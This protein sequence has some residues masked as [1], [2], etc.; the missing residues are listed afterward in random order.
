MAE[1]GADRQPPRRG[2]WRKRC[3]ITLLLLCAFPIAIWVTSP[4][5][6]P[7]A[8]QLALRWTPVSVTTINYDADGRLRLTGAHYSADG[9]DAVVEQMRVPAPAQILSAWLTTRRL[10]DVT[11]ETWQVTID[12]DAAG[13][14]TTGEPIQADDIHLPETL[15]HW[16]GLL[17]KWRWLIPS[18]SIRSGT[19]A[20]GDETFAVDE[21][22]WMDTTLALQASSSQWPSPVAATFTV[23]DDDSIAGTIE[24]AEMELTLAILI[25]AGE[26]SASINSTLQW[27]DNVGEVVV[28][29]PRQ[30]ILPSRVR[31]DIP[32]FIIPTDI[33]QLDGYN[34]PV[35]DIHISGTIGAYS[36]ALKIAAEPDADSSL[37]PLLIALNASGSEHQLEIGTISIEGDFVEGSLSS[38]IHFDLNQPDQLTATRFDF[39]ADLG[40]Q[41]IVPVSGIME[42]TIAVAEHRLA[43]G[44]I[45]EVT[46]EFTATDLIWETIAVNR[47]EAQARLR[48]PTLE[49]T[50]LAIESDAVTAQLS[51]SVH[52]TEQTIDT[53]SFTMEVRP[54]IEAVF[55]D[56]TLPY[57]FETIRSEGSIDGHW[58]D[59][60]HSG[61]IEIAGVE[62]P[63]VGKGSITAEW[64]GV[65]LAISSSISARLLNLAA[66]AR[67]EVNQISPT[68]WTA[69]L[70][71]VEFQPAEGSSFALV[72]PTDIQIDLAELAGDALIPLHLSISPLIVQRESDGTH[73]ISLEIAGVTPT[74]GNLTLEI[75]GLSANDAGALLQLPPGVQSATV[76]ELS[77]ATSWDNGPLS[78]SLTLAAGAQVE[79]LLP[80]SAKISL[81]LAD[82]LLDIDTLHVSQ[83][84]K[85]A[86][87]GSASLPLTLSLLDEKLLTIHPSAPL[88]ATFT[89]D[90][91]APAWATI[92][93]LSGARI[94]QPLLALDLSG[95]PNSPRGS[96]RLDV[97][98]ITSPEM[99]L[100]LE[101]EINDLHFNLLIDPSGLNLEAFTF[102]VFQ[103]PVSASGSW[104][105][106][107][108]DWVGFLSSGELPPHSNAQA[109]IETTDFPLSIFEKLLPAVVRPQGVLSSSLA[110]NTEQG[111]TG[112]ATVRDVATFPLPSIGTVSNINTSITIDNHILSVDAF[113]ATIGGQTL[114]ITGTVDLK[115][116][117]LPR[118]DLHATA[119]QLPLLRSPG[120]IMRAEDIAI[121][122]VTG[123]DD[124]TTVSGTIHMAESFLLVDFNDLRATTTSADN[125]P[126]FFAVEDQPFANWA[127]NVEIVGDRFL[128]VSTP[129]FDGVIS[130]DF[131]LGGNLGA[132][133]SHG[134]ASVQRGYVKFPFALFTVSQ[135]EIAID[136]SA[137]YTIRINL[138][139]S[140]RSYG[141]DLRMQ[142]TGTADEP[143]L[144]F[145]STPTLENADI[146]LLATAGRIPQGGT[147]MSSSSRLSGLGLFLGS[148][149]LAELG[150][151]D[152]YSDRLQIR[153]GED[154][155]EQGRDTIQVEFRLNERASIIGEY[156][157]FDAYNLDFKYLIYSRQ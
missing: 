143:I 9:V 69:R 25:A 4:W 91:D 73:V 51:G 146:L 39:A 134:V 142:L 132:P 82:D 121:H 84:D 77:L 130:A 11:I 125:P 47:I 106:S 138:D 113:N 81:T 100:P 71:T 116:L 24:M 87:S 56:I 70:L 110:F 3:L 150:L 86:L 23:N 55:P 21:M 103:H 40:K 72:A 104:P 157:R 74:S 63:T 80:I 137:P 48:W 68:E 95:T 85:P 8:L 62:L 1:S 57:P 53:A 122:I 144:Q 66:D 64:Q 37:P 22:K 127:L 5:W 108:K 101:M 112:T 30:G 99:E 54:E 19:V 32:A 65:A 155:S 2:K 89:T 154:V 44:T 148:T 114:G 97:A 43:D 96:L 123:G 128:R 109:T 145:S 120:L 136:P 147:E 151:V 141:Y 105:I 26:S 6:F 42:G 46:F 7:S 83:S 94:A 111:L 15:T 59:P 153:L 75:N 98:S 152:P 36:A 78:A 135:G 29:W 131:R 34:Q 50:S 58:S 156:D 79:D 76:N 27:I 16:I 10:P 88:A 67:I 45:P 102:T 52:L 14:E 107:Q 115:D 60:H 20:I 118:Y 124:I 117:P 28:E 129:V 119:R 41:H 35:V 92:E 12:P 33:L 38:P 13:A 139:A 93:Q 61:S 133:V 18:I 149:F 140:G 49:L 17:Q 90:P 31:I 126:P